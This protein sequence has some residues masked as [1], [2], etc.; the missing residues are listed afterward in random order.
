MNEI[1]QTKVPQTPTVSVTRPAQKVQ[2]KSGG[3][4]GTIVLGCFLIFLLLIG[5]LAYASFMIFKN[6]GKPI[7]LGVV[8]ST[9]DFNQFIAESGLELKSEATQLCFTCDVKWEGVQEAE[10]KLSNE[11]ASAWFDAVNSGLGVIDNTQIKFEDGK[12]TIATMFT[13][14]G[15]ALPVMIS[16]GLEKV[17]DTSVAVDL[18][19]LKVGG[20][21]IPGEYVVQVE[22]ALEDFTNSKIAEIPEFKLDTLEIKADYLDF[23]GDIP[24]SVEA[25]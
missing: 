15:I 17:T 10:I 4:F 19:T 2:K 5:G 20:L 11:E 14:E 18:Q 1:N 13:Y 8:A 3:F 25:L 12:V 22:A 6:I 7:D 9:K 21:S 16:G 24:E 23:S